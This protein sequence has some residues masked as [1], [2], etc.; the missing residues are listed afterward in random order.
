MRIFLGL[1]TKNRMVG[2][3]NRMDS[4][5]CWSDSCPVGS[6][7]K[8]V[9]VCLWLDHYLRKVNGFLKE[10]VVHPVLKKANS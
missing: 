3:L 7:R 1:H 5:V 4:S 10:E 2:A 9:K 6:F 8:Q